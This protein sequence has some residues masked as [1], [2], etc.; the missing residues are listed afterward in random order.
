MG[1]SRISAMH[2]IGVLV[3]LFIAAV[4]WYAIHLAPPTP[5]SVVTGP[6]AYW[7]EAVSPDRSLMAVCIRYG[8]YDADADHFDLAIVRLDTGEGRIVQTSARHGFF[9]DVHF[10][11]PGRVAYLDLT[12]R[13]TGRESWARWRMVSVSVDGTDRQVH[14]EYGAGQGTIRQIDAAHGRLFWSQWVFPDTYK[15]WIA[16]RHAGKPRLVAR[17]GKGGGWIRVSPDG[18]CVYYMKET[19]TEEE[20]STRLCRIDVDTGAQEEY[21]GGPTRG[22]Y[23]E[24]SPGGARV[25]CFDPY[26][27]LAVLDVRARA[28]RVAPHR[29]ALVGIHWIDD[30]RFVTTGHFAGTWLFDWRTDPPPRRQL[31][32][33]RIHLIAWFPARRAFLVQRDQRFLFY[34]PATG[35]E[36]LVPVKIRPDHS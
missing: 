35:N 22:Q 36:T 2:V 29:D 21:P 16:D 30:D 18:R 13:P 7:S 11:D 19:S 9:T 27:G 14:A 32:K 4:V 28:W 10:V 12:V 8:P 33:D 25:A 31:A 23:P 24:C 6:S 1:M 20:W 34:D 17:L 3:V 26:E 15:L 5:A